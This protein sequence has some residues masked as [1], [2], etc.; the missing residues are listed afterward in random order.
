MPGRRFDGAYERELGTAPD[1]AMREL[2]AQARSLGA[3][4]A[5][6]ID[7]DHEKPGANGGMLMVSAS[8]TAVALK[9]EG[10]ASGPWTRP[11][12]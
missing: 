7:P 4:A 12:G 6:G 10:S 5:I 2:P 8:G 3:D 11:A 1:T 9:A